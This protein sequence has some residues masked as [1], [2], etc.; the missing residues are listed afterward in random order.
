[1]CIL[2]L[3]LKNIL[4]ISIVAVRTVLRVKQGA[5][6]QKGF[7]GIS[8]GF[9]GHQ[10]GQFWDPIKVLKDDGRRLVSRKVRSNLRATQIS[11][12]FDSIETNSE[13]LYSNLQ[14]RKS[15]IFK[16]LGPQHSLHF[17]RNSEIVFV[18]VFFLTSIARSRL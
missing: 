3:I 4:A 6:D 18:F 7:K 10:G 17:S 16:N 8:R 14:L 11:Y 12:D 5:N 2:L 9:Q 13:N 15:G 1:M